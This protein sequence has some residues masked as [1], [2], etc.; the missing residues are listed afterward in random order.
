VEKD[1]VAQPLGEARMVAV[2]HRRFHG[3][4]P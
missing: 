1:A 3:K 4:G 2:R